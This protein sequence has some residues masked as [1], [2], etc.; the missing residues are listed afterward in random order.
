MRE[1][2]VWICGKYIEH[3]DHGVVWELQGVFSS[4]ELGREACQTAA[5][6][7]GPITLGDTLPDESTEWPGC[8]YPLAHAP[9]QEMVR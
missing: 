7:I 9:A 3:T 5:Y 2:E 1:P 4:E 6:F 8:Y